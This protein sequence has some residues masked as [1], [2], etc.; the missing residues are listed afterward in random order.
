MDDFTNA[1]YQYYPFPNDSSRRGL[2]V[3]AE[4]RTYQFGGNL[5]DA[6]VVKW[7][8]KNKSLR[9][10]NKCY[11]GFYGDPHIG[12]SVDFS[13]DLTYF[14]DR[15]GPVGDTARYW[16]RNTVYVW[17]ADGLGQGG[18]PTGYMSF[19]FLQTP[20]DNDLT[21]FYALGYTNSLPNV[22]KNDV[23]F[24][25]LLS[26]DSIAHD[27]SLF[28][29]P[30]DN[31]L[32]FGT[33]PFSLPAGD[34]TNISLAIF[35]SDNYADMLDDANYIHFA[36]HWP[37]IGSNIGQEGGDVNYRID[38]TSP[39]SGVVNG[40][41]PVT[42]QY[43]GND[44]NAR[45]LLEYSSNRG[46]TWKPLVWNHP[47]HQ[48]FTWST[49]TV[50]DG[51]NYLLRIVAH[52]SDLSRYY[53]DITD[54]RFTVNNP[55]NAQPELELDRSFEGTM[56]RH[57]PLIISWTAEDADNTS[58]SVTISSAFRPSG[59]FTQVQSANY[60]AGSNSFSWDFS[61]S[62][63]AAS[64][65]LRVIASDGALADTVVSE[66]F[67][68]NQEE[69]HYQQAVFQ[70]IAGRST[71]DLNLQV[72]NPSELTN[73]SYE[74]SFNVVHP[75]STKHF[76]VRDLMT[77]STVISN[78]PIL[79]GISTPLFDGLK[80]TVADKPTDISLTKSRFNRGQ[81][82]TTVRFEWTVLPSL[83]QIKVAQDWI[84]A[85]NNLD[86]LPSGAWKFPGDTVYTI[87]DN[88]TAVCPFYVVNLDSIQKATYRVLGGS[89]FNGR[90]DFNDAIVLQPQGTTG[91]TFSYQVAF[92]FGS[93][94]FPRQ[95]DT[96]RIMTDKTITAVDTFRFVGDSNFV[97]AVRSGP[98][99]LEYRLSN[100][101]PN[102]FNPK[103]TI[104]FSL[105]RAG[106]VS[107]LVYDLLGREV[108]RLVREMK[109]PG[110][111]TVTWD[112]RGVASGVYF[113]RFNVLDETGKILFSNTNKLVL[114][115]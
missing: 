81:L 85:F 24:W 40:D 82:D 36:S 112:A 66:A 8:L 86:S 74:L 91:N 32:V 88:Y 39:N 38:I 30:G 113:G 26:T 83:P 11:F 42:W 110:T 44:Q 69:G 53:Y 68:I 62:P 46:S 73:H 21:T 92:D 59:P 17:D 5:Q 78:D 99:A 20:N 87:S 70:H 51:V 22:P 65:Y 37:N 115:K 77:G 93:G 75:E 98:L 80:L 52:S 76:S 89:P 19:K 101:Y 84:I 55:V 57:A 72:I 63:N 60:P 61:A 13:D 41:V 3:S 23:L 97:T 28:T 15:S 106:E 35:F 25:Q 45:V 100:N 54:Q 29:T 90:W 71:P 1:K 6:I 27:Q 108:A 67:S 48:P 79:S 105:P 50:A 102:P 95:G 33:G 64:Y 2:G 4:V 7:K 34:S 43:N 14:V 16:A 114:L 104:T 103:T 96:L 9:P 111:Y 56:V 18:S 12:G 47:L 10:L 94:I 31:V 49:S 107:L 109:Q 58:V